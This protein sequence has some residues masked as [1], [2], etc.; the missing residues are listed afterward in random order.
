MIRKIILAIVI[1]SVFFFGSIETVFAETHINK[2]ITQNTYWTK[3]GSPYIVDS[4]IS[5][6]NGAV[7]NIGPGVEVQTGPYLNQ[8][9]KQPYTINIYNSSLFING[10]GNNRVYINN[11]RALIFKNATG[12]IANA[13]LSH[14]VISLT[15]STSTIATSTITGP[16]YL[17]SALYVKNGALSMWGSRIT[18]GGSRSVTADIPGIPEVFNGTTQ[19]LFA[20]AAAGKILDENYYSPIRI[21]GSSINGTSTYAISN[22]SQFVVHASGNW[23]GSPSGPIKGPISG[24]HNQVAGAITYEP[25]LNSEPSLDPGNDDQENECCSS[26]LFIPG[27]ESSRLYKDELGILGIGTSTNTLWEP[28]SNSDVTK[29]F[30]D[31]DGSSMDPSI[32]SGGPIDSAWGYDVYGKFMNFLDDLVDMGI[33]NEWKSFGYDWRKPIAEVVAGMEKKATSTESL[34]QIVNDE[35]AHS[36]TGKVTIIAHSNGGLVAEYL[37]KTLVDMGK[38]YLIDAVISVAVPT[39]GT[40]KAILSLLHGFDQS[41]AGGLMLKESVAKELAMNMPSAY[42]LLPSLAYFSKVSSPTIKFSS[43]TIHSYDEQ[44][45]FI[46]NNSNSSLMASAGLL[47][48]I[49]DTFSWPNNIVH[50]AIAGWNVNTPSGISYATAN[51]YNS[52]YKP[53]ITTMGDGTVVTPSAVYGGGNNIISLNLEGISKDES[54]NITHGN[55]LES[56]TTQAVISKIISNQNIP[57][58]FI[59]GIVPNT[60]TGE[61]DYTADKSFIIISTHSPVQPHVYDSRGNHTGEITPPIDAE[62]FAWAY[63]N[64]IPG[65]SFYRTGKD[66]GTYIYVPDNGE[67]YNVILKGTGTGSFTLYIER[68]VNGV[69]VDNVQYVGVPVTSHTVAST[70]IQIPQSHSDNNNNES[71]SS[72]VEKLSVDLDGSGSSDIQVSPNEDNANT[73]NSNSYACPVI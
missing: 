24:A 32:Y 40:P 44:S 21:H 42:S 5:V 3:A 20:A 61:P 38:S 59:T 52:T 47:H 46:A 68:Q 16:T 26:V 11:L 70:G 63:E 43:T 37:I 54:K 36:K 49:I 39:L 34:V 6:L 15:T 33:F 50:W 28:N 72:Y 35:A 4:N 10:K 64:K 65:S 22:L 9:G 48:N 27:I 71:L 41:I 12:T 13:D 7:L 2:D 62:D 56:S 66:M 19:E 60:K 30:M 57:P 73:N 58:D 51:T 29:L 25:W 14:T 17:A 18:N 31:T 53:I 8:P 55:I 67:K 69:I 1:I 23:W 45:D